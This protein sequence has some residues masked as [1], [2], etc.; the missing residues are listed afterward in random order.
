M[1]L[2]KINTDDPKDTA[3]RGHKLRRGYGVVARRRRLDGMKYAALFS[4]STAR[5]SDRPGYTFPQSR[6]EVDEHLY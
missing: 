2:L 6:L 5:T 1:G 3:A 4:H